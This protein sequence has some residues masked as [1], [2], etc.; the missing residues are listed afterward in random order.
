[1][2]K[3]SGSLAAGDV[4]VS[5]FEVQTLTF[6][7]ADFIPTGFEVTGIGVIQIAPTYD[8]GSVILSCPTQA[9]STQYLRDVTM[10][11]AGEG[12]MLQCG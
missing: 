6:D 7:F 5:I 12:A 3:T 11:N 8:G 10:G 9:D 2:P 1:M 4:L